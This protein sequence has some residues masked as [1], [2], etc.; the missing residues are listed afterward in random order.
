MEEGQSASCHHI[1]TLATNPITE[2]K[3]P[4]MFN[5]T[6]RFQVIRALPVATLALALLLAPHSVMDNGNGKQQPTVV[7]NVNGKHRPNLSE[8]PTA[9]G[10]GTDVAW[11]S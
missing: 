2:R 3:K 5:R 10:T 4:P 6:A 8:M 9:D 7:D 1:L 11:N